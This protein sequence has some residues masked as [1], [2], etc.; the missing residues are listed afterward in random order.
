MNE[1]HHEDAR[2]KTNDDEVIPKNFQDEK[3][4][5]NISSTNL[6]AHDTTQANTGYQSRF[7]DKP[8]SS[9]PSATVEVFFFKI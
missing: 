4:S 7:S 5:I 8:P 9:I 6:S 1:D 3:I 2:M